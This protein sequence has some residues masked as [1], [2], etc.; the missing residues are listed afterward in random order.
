MFSFKKKSKHQ[1]D[2]Q[3]PLLSQ[4]NLQVVEHSFS[5]LH[6]K[7]KKVFS[8][9]M[10]NFMLES[11]MSKSKIHNFQEQLKDIKNPHSYIIR[12][13]YEKDESYMKQFCINCIVYLNDEHIR[14]PINNL[15][16]FDNPSIFNDIYKHILAPLISELMNGY[17]AENIEY[18]DYSNITNFDAYTTNTSETRQKLD[19]QTTKYNIIEID[20]LSSEELE[21]FIHKFN[22][23]L[24]FISYEY[25]D[26]NIEI[27][28]N[29]SQ[30]YIPM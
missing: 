1:K 13:I 19:E 16:I 9:K 7:Y 4:I 8:K 22:C 21:K 2:E 18:Q 24:P 11:N 14:V 17:E 12:N 25:L 30:C 20:T 6:K 28:F 3:Q 26:F 29:I 5:V 15:V 10:L 27:M 23:K